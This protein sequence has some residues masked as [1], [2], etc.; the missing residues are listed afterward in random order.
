MLKISPAAAVV[1]GGRLEG[2]DDVA[3]VDQTQKF[4]LPADRREPSFPDHPEVIQ[5]IL[6]PRTEDGRDAED[7]DVH[8]VPELQGLLLG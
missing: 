8:F 1:A 6:I 5:K 2:P 7:D 4:L 3:D